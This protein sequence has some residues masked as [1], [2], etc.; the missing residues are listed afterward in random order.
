[1]NRPFKYTL[2]TGDFLSIASG[3]AKP[4]GTAQPNLSDANGNM[5]GRYSNSMTYDVENRSTRNSHSTVPTDYGFTCHTSDW[6]SVFWG[7]YRHT[8]S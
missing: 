5:V 4:S 6:M 1:M 2:A 7:S 3:C 8:S